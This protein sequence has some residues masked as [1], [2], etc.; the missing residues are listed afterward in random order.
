MKQKISELKNIRQFGQT[1]NITIVRS[2]K[3]VHALDLPSVLNLNPR[4]VYNKIDEFY[5]LV[6][7]E[8]ADVVFM[9]ESWER[10]NQT[11]DQIIN[12]KDHVVISN[13]YQ[14][15]GV[16]GRPALIVNRKK[17]DVQNLTQSVVQIPWGVEMVWAVITPKN[18]QSDSKIQKI[19]LGALYSKPNSRKKTVTLDHIS[20]VFTQMSVKYQKG[21]HFIIAGDTN[22][23]KLDYILQLSPKIK[24]V[25]TEVTRLNPP[26]ILDPILTTLSQYYQKP[27]VLPP[28]DQD[29][30]K[31]GKPSDHKIV[32]MKPI[33][34]VNN[35]PARS[36]RQV[37]FCPTPE[38]GMNIMK[39]WAG[40][41]NWENVINA[42]SHHEKANILQAT[43]K[44]CIRPVLAN[45]DS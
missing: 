1:N 39:Q 24:Q 11:L 19:I 20:D 8:E 16:G 45:K 28:L 37:V 14:R 15:L 23:L 30:N 13:V 4:S 33:D 29:P 43:L 6:Q 36:T 34:S 40:E 18:I 2:N 27:I 44:K 10:E 21:L 25:V 5:T 22:D 12:L 31:N 3:L 32:K 35:K 9:S 38:S 26:R 42:S 7:E 41:Q 17:F